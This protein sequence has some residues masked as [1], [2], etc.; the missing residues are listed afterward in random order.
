META[1]QSIGV[2]RS[3]TPME[4][5]VLI[6]NIASLQ[7]SIFRGW[8]VHRSKVRQDKDGVE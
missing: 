5:Y 6:A 8:H 3:A 4:K 1:R 7:K 2:K